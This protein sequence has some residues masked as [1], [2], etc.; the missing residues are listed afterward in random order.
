MTTPPRRGAFSIS[1][2]GEISRKYGTMPLTRL[3][4]TLNR[5]P[6]SVERRA[7]R[8]FQGTP[9]TGAWTKAETVTLTTMLG[10]ATAEQIGTILRRAPA[11]VRTATARLRSRTKRKKPLIDAE[12]GEFKAVYSSRTDE[13]LCAMFGVTLEVIAEMAE[14]QCLQKDKAFLRTQGAAST[15]MPRW[16]KA[17]IERL[18]SIYSDSS[19]HEIAQRLK[20]SIKSI[21]SKAHSLGLKKNPERLRQM[22]RD[23]VSKRYQ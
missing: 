22:G 15:K 12:L 14:Q 2:D 3:A 16:T 17:E 8:L 13:D 4:Q 19:N 23:N 10:T 7:Q 11:D 9:V 1:E 20:R 21:V 18:T 6:T 5:N